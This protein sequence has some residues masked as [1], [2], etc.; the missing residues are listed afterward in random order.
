[1]ANYV[2]SSKLGVDLTQSS[3]ASNF[4][5]GDIVRGTDGSIWQYAQAG[6]AVSA[7]SVVAING[8]GSMNMGLISQRPCAFA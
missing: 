5:L 2:A 4:A 3:A 7:Y 1:M 8:S 6:A